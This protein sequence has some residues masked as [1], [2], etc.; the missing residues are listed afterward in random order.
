VRTRITWPQRSPLAAS[1]RSGFAP[2]GPT[3]HGAVTPS[4]TEASELDEG[5]PVELAADYEHLR[6]LVPTFTVLGGCCGTD[7][8]HIAAIAALIQ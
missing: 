1:G 3:P 6:A 5:D 7:V 8:R 4:W 2:C